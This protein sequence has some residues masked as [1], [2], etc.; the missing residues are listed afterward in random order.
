MQYR[1]G[2]GYDI[3]R[4]VEGRKLFLGAVEI[5]YTKGLLGHSDGDVLIHA[6]CDALLGALALGDIG[7]YFPD[8]DPQY[9]G[10]ASSRLLKIVKELLD[11]SGYK[12]NNLDVIIIAQE[13][14]LIPFKVH[15]KEK[16]CALLGIAQDVLNIKA[17][18]NE[19]LDAV[20][21]REAIAC[22]ATASLTR[23]E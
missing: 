2:M 10:I 21:Q 17:K 13:P 22:Y 11:K 7:E 12:I 15:I 1:V 23:G 19:G 20:G 5:P 9:Q 14:K 4:L 3:H 18:T 16:I 8:T 6:L